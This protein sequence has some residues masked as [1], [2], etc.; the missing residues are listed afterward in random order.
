MY[1]ELLPYFLTF[2]NRTQRLQERIQK[3][4]PVLQERIMSLLQTPVIG[5]PDLK[6]CDHIRQDRIRMHRNDLSRFASFLK[7][8]RRRI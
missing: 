8:L 7:E 3:L 1:W 5:E 4:L 2:I 6:A